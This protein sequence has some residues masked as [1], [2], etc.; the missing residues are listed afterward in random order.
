MRYKIKNIN[1]RSENAAKSGSQTARAVVEWIQRQSKVRSVLDLGCGKLRYARY[2]AEKCDYLSLV[3]S[4]I[5]IERFQIIENCR[6]TVKDYASKNWPNAEVDAIEKFWDKPRRKYDLV[7]CANV[8]SAIPSKRVRTQTL[9][10][11]LKILKKGGHILVVN[12]YTN[13]YFKRMMRSGKTIPHLDGYIL[14]STR[15]NYY[16]GLLHEAKMSKILS[17]CGFNIIDH[18][19]KEQSAFVLAGV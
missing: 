4:R 5:Q 15:G 16:Y 14:I 10:N 18:W 19:R 3:D 11:V 17:E 6:T 7:F 1:I 13:S 12:Q 2:L 9:V 8:I